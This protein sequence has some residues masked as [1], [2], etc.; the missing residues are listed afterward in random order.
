MVYEVKPEAIIEE[1]KEQLKSEIE[2]PE[3]GSHIKT[4]VAG[5]K[6]PQQDDWWERRAASMM[7]KLY[8]N[9]PI[10]VRGITKQ[11]GDTDRRG[12]GQPH[13]RTASRNVTRTIFQQLEDAGY[14]QTI[15]GEGRDLT[16]DGR[17]L[18]DNLTKE[19]TPVEA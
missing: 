2:A 5:E 10:G 13:F 11:Y 18:L 4:K 8:V 1:L 16:P 3:W 15:E 7:R 6:S 14:V 17:S 9:G 19:L 12:V